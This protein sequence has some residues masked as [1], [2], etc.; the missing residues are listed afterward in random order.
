MRLGRRLVLVTAVTALLGGPVVATASAASAASAAGAGQGWV[1]CADLS[2]GTPEDVYLYPFGNPSHPTMLMH[3]GYGS[4]TEYMPLSAGQYTLAMRPP[5]APASSPPTVSTSFM[6]SAGSNYTVASIGSASSRRLKVLNDQ[7]AAAAGSKALIRVIQASVKQ[8]QVTVSVGSDVLARELGF[9]SASSYQSVKPGSP[10]VT[11]SAQGGHAAM[12]VKL[13]AGSVH[14]LVVLDGSSGLRIDNLTDAAG[15]TDRP[16]GGAATGFG[17]TAPK[18]GPGLLPWLGTLA[19]GLLLAV[20][21]GFSLRRSRRRTAAAAGRLRR[22]R[23]RRLVLGWLA[24]CRLV[25]AQ[26]PRLRRRASRVTRSAGMSAMPAVSVSPEIRGA[27]V[28]SVQSPGQA[29]RV[30][31]GPEIIGSTAGGAGRGWW[32]ARSA[33]RG[34]SGR[35][36]RR[37]TARPGRARARPPF[38][39]AASAGHGLSCG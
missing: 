23:L 11:F 19:G 9:G 21:G 38:A 3:Q 39:V 24:L 37:P 15:S 31:R 18:A 1:R 35:W 22:L 36:R 10:T 27:A 26:R 34:C 28:H 8:P 6:V 30:G 14:T 29:A 33:G 5:G 16:K 32:T 2:P 20:A 12:A 17:G 25:L 13:T 4:V 7:M